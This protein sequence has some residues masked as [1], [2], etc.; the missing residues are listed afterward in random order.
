MHPRWSP[1]CKKPPRAVSQNCGPL[2]QAF[3]V[4]RRPSWPP[5]PM[6]GVKD[7]SK[8]RSIASNSSNAKRTDEP[9]LT[10]SGIEYWLVLHELS[11]GDDG[12]PAFRVL[13]IY[14]SGL[15]YYVSFF[16][17]RDIWICTLPNNLAT[18][19][20]KMGCGKE[21]VQHR[22]DTGPTEVWRM[23]DE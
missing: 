2:P 20:Q 6:P 23:C 17:K 4:S 11:P 9:G 1:G 21:R 3:S 13:D 22:F 18:L 12:E 14:W 16:Q 8:G 15:K 10:C 19:P 5:S 7:R